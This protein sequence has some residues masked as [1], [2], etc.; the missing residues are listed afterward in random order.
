MS[1]TDIVDDGTHLKLHICYFERA[2]M[3]Y[4]YFL[5]P[6]LAL[7]I[8]DEKCKQQCFARQNL[9]LITTFSSFNTAFDV[10]RKEPQAFLFAEADTIIQNLFGNLFT[11]CMLT[12]YIGSLFSSKIY[13]LICAHCRMLLFGYKT[14]R[15]FCILRV[16][17]HRK[18]G[19]K[20]I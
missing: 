8:Y 10:A 12:D 19:I 2:S 3:G 14:A 5:L 11:I 20:Y 16:K 7:V 17:L 4:S 1:W 18:N 13:I 15:T 6:L 9:C